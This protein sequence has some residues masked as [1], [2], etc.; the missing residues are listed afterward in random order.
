MARPL[1]LTGTALDWCGV[2]AH[3]AALR[4][5]PLSLVQPLALSALVFAVPAE[6]LLSRRRPTHTQTLAAAQTAVG[7]ALI[8]V[9][10]GRPTH[11]TGSL[12]TSVAGTA[13]LLAILGPA[14]FASRCRSQRVQAMLLGIGA[15]SAYGLSAALVRATELTASTHIDWL[16]GAVGAVVAGSV[17]LLLSQAA[18]H[19]GRLSWSMPSQDFVALVVSISAGALLLSET[20]RFTDFTLIGT[21]AAVSLVVHGIIRLNRSAAPERSTMTGPPAA[22]DDAYPKQPVV[23]GRSPSR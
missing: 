14:A 17:G 20:P 15:G 2:L 22:H 8:V 1:W 9:L 13:A 6:S 7:L 11:S 5:G 21:L 12:P 19:R 18:L 10:I 4:F 23:P 16:L 3:V